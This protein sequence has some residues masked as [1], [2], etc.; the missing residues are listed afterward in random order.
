MKKSLFEKSFRTNS[1]KMKLTEEK[2]L[3]GIKA[4]TIAD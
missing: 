2:L 4:V 3:N 1:L